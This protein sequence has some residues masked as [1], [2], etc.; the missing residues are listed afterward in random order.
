MGLLVIDFDWFLFLSVG[1]PLLQKDLLH[2]LSIVSDRK[3]KQTLS[4][5]ISNFE[6]DSKSQ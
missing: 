3:I 5:S 4:P 1:S 6:V 2:L